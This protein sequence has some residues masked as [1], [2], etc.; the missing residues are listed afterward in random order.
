MIILIIY[1]ICHLPAFILII[2]GRNL[3]A[4]KPNTAKVLFIIAG[5]YFMIGAGICGNLL[6][7]EF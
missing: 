4:K 2:V 3:R 1:L 7:I 5:V 6:S